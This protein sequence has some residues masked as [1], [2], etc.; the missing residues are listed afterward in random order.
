[1]VCIPDS[2]AAGRATTQAA[3]SGAT[4]DKLDAAHRAA[5]GSVKTPHLT[6]PPH[7]A[8]CNEQPALT[9]ALNTFS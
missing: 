6:S 7:P 9:L 2:D 8:Y 1:M 5:A 4:P 3:A